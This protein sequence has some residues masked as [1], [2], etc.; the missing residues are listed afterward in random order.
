MCVGGGLFYPIP[1][2]GVL[3]QGMIVYQLEGLL[4]IM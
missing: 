3:P 2:S 4:V 1:E